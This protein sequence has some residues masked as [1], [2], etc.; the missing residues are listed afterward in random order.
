MKIVKNGGVKKIF[1]D[2]SKRHFYFISFYVLGLPLKIEK[3][4]LLV[5][6][7]VNIFVS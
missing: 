6:T 3:I 2:I 4:Y 5:V 7:E 1:L